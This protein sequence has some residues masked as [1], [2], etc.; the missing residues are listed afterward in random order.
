MAIGSVGALDQPHEVACPRH[1][2]RVARV[3]D[4]EQRPQYPAALEAADL[5]ADAPQSCAHDPEANQLVAATDGHEVAAVEAAIPPGAAAP[6][7]HGGRDDT[8]LEQATK[9]GAPQA[10]HLHHLVERVGRAV[11]TPA[12]HGRPVARSERDTN[13]LNGKAGTA[14]KTNK[15]GNNGTN[16]VLSTADG[17]QLRACPR[18]G[19][20]VHPHRAVAQPLTGA[21]VQRASVAVVARERPILAR[22]GCV[23]DVGGARFAIVAVLG[24]GTA[25]GAD[26]RKVVVA[27]PALQPPFT[28]ASEIVVSGPDDG[29]I[30]LA[31]GFGSH[32]ETVK[33]TRDRGDG[34]VCELA[35]G[36]LVP[37]DRGVV[38][39]TAYEADP[40]GPRRA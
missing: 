2:E 1:V 13:G 38:E 40:V 39:L 27:N 37:E 28:D 17:V 36:T 32:G 35:G 29:T 14:G 24:L 6:A 33:R 8:P 31:N 25:S 9:L 10:E 20:D 26:G 5:L 7:G 30:V 22:A 12:R 21:V 34:H 16:A 19:T 4:G 15:A 18:A 23:T 3:G 11:I